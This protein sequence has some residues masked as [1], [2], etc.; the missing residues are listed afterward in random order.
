MIVKGLN[1][2]VGKTTPPSGEPCGVAGGAVAI[3]GGDAAQQDVLNCKSV[4]VCEGFRCHA[5][6]L[7]PP[8]VEEALLQLLHHIVCVSGPF[9]FVIDVY[10]EKLEV[11]LLLHCGP[12]NVDRGVFPLLLP[13][14]HDHLVC[15]VDVDVE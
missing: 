6:F 5:K 10:T 13:E 2:C 4:K 14:V 9:Q 12:V 1:R 3:P 11:F 15:F 8:E 7:Q